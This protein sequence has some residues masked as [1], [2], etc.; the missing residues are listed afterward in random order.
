M[1]N[2]VNSGVLRGRPFDGVAELINVDLRSVC[3]KLYRLSIIVLLKFP[4]GL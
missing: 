1:S 3:T 4:I 2:M